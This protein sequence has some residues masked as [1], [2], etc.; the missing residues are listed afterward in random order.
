MHLLSIIIKSGLYKTMCSVKPVKLLL[1]SLI[2]D[3]DE[4]KVNQEYSDFTTKK[5]GQCCTYNTSYTE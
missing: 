5:E 1:F 4:F 2:S 3:V